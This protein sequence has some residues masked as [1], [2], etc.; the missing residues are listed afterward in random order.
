MEKKTNR[1]KLAPLEKVAVS[2]LEAGS[3]LGLNEKTVRKGIEDGVI[4]KLE[5]GKR[6]LI[7]AWWLRQQ[8]NGTPGTAA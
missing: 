3:L 4:P 6:V 5:I 8:L 2:A 1:T 7:P